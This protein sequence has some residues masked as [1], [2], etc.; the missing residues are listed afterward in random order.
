MI[1][2]LSVLCAIVGFGAHRIIRE[3]RRDRVASSEEAAKIRHHTEVQV[4]KAN[5]VPTAFLDSMMLPSWY[6]D[7]TGVMRYI[8]SAYT[9]TFNVS[10]AE[11]IGKTDY[12][13]WPA[14]IARAFRRHDAMV[15][16]QRATIQFHELI[17]TSDRSLPPQQWFVCKFPVID[18]ISGEV[19][20]VGGW[21]MPK[22]MADRGSS[23][24]MSSWRS[25]ESGTLVAGDAEFVSLS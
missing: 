12:E 3:L 20:G 5:G 15:V 24:T 21:C 25:V 8:N 11:Y 10:P 6:K 4:V 22:S 1:L 14:E 19:K 16:A 18:P 13:V 17:P 2:A 9:M 23:S 7:V